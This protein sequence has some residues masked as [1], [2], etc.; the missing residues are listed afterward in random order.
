M[1]DLSAGTVTF[2]FTDIEGST[3]LLRQL[4]DD[5]G[6]AL[7][8]HQ[9]LLRAA[10]ARAGGEEI[11][12][13]GDSFFVAFRRA[14]DAV[15][16]AVEAQRS[17]A[18]HTWPRGV[19]V[20]VRI[21]IHT[22]E[23]AVEEGRYL[24]LAVHRAARICA[25]A[26]GGQILLSHT[27]QT[28]LE[29]EEAE[30]RD[31]ALRDLGEQRLKDFDRPLHLHQ[32]V[33][34]GLSEEFPPLRTGLDEAASTMPFAGREDELAEAAHEA[35]RPG[36]L[37]RRRGTV[38]LAGAVGVVL[39]AV[40]IAA[41]LAR[42]G[43][44]SPAGPPAAVP[45]KPNSL[46]A[47]DP[48]TG[49]VKKVIAVGSAP[50][51][52]VFAAN[53]IWVL[54]EYD[55]TITR[56]DPSTEMSTT[57]PAA[58]DSPCCLALERG[59]GV[60]VSGYGT[61]EVKRLNLTTSQPDHSIRVGEVVHG[62]VDSLALL[63]R[64]SS[65]IAVG[66]GSLWLVDPTADLVRRVNLRTRRTV[67]YSVAD[68]PFG[69]TYAEGSAWVASYGGDAVTEIR[70]SDAETREISSPG[71]PVNLAVDD[72]ALWVGSFS[73]GR[74][75]RIDAQSGGAT[76]IV[77]TGAGSATVVHIDLAIGFGAVWATSGTGTL[78]RIDLDDPNDV[79]RID[80]GHRAGGI[81]LG[82][83]AVWV[84]VQEPTT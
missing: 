21:G 47:I 76:N 83:G 41:L 32:V 45:V 11:D 55:R 8:D 3:R 37:S 59:N 69:A 19:E 49:K 81:A 73:D 29:D 34:P 24:G 63:P 10:F 31:V 30:M 61:G 5:Y 72:G 39:A 58:L 57:F 48:S 22:G 7:A 2:L 62:T 4:R 82:A 75:R 46:V 74:A 53:S 79:R 23:A 68:R 1:P 15:A 16:A 40:A 9:R 44:E 60:W 33:V 42:G 80:L 78:T 18:G 35:V 12:T 6:K 67:E 20:R 54:N 64:L 13:Q 38:G 43:E 50:S 77:E 25:A 36:F 56:F 17:L 14:R 26:H 51:A 27:T 70:A 71:G 66:G 65:L 28:L 84:T 52:A